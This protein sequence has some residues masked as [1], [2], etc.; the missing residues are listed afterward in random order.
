MAGMTWTRFADLIFV[1]GAGWFLSGAIEARRAGNKDKGQVL[2][3]LGLFWLGLSIFE[4]W[5]TR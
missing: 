4:F 3:V 1:F 2:L 5:P